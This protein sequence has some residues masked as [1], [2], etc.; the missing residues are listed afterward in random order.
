MTIT[1]RVYG[2]P[3]T[4]GSAKGFAIPNK[5]KPG[6]HRVIITND[7]PNNKAW[8]AVVSGEAQR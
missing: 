7:N 1:F 5:N 4:K 8:A 6:H 3:K 2:I